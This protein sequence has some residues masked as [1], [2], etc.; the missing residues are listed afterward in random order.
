MIGFPVLVIAISD[1]LDRNDGQLILLL[2]RAAAHR[3][4]IVAGLQDLCIVTV[5]VKD[6]GYVRYWYL[7]LSGVWG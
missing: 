1:I 4:A 7:K 3:P 6:F 5:N 2:G